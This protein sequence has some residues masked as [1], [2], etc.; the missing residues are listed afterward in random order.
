MSIP[1]QQFLQHIPLF[2]ACAPEDRAWLAT[3][4]EERRFTKGQVL[5]RQGD[6]CEGMHVF[7]VGV[8]KLGLLRR[9]GAEK[10]VEIIQA[11]QS[12]GEAVMFLDQPYPVLGEALSDTL[13]LHIGSAAVF[14]QIEQDP[15]FARKLLAGMSIRLHS[16]VRDVES[17]A[18]RSSTQRVIGYLLQLAD[19]TPCAAGGRHEVELPTSKQVIASRLSLTP[20]TLSRIFH[21]LSDSGLISVQGKHI[22]IH[23]AARLAEHD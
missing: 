7:I 14:G 5:F 4:S 16:M 17:Y 15:C 19:S 11:G 22:V 12:F 9:G 18:L 23:D 10:V 2:A 6:A 8:I 13:L 20:E 21:E 1:L 3:S